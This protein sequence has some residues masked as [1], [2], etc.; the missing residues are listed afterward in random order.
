MVNE[1]INLEN[2]RMELAEMKTQIDEMGASL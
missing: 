1:V 2:R